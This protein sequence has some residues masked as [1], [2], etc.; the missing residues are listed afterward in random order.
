MSRNST[1]SADEAALTYVSVWKS[2]AS[3]LKL[4]GQLSINPLNSPFARRLSNHYQVE[5]KDL[6][7]LE[8]ISYREESLV[9]GQEILRRG[10][11]LSIQ[12]YRAPVP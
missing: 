11:E 5:E 9:P 4:G 3:H 6:E 2:S 7:Q 8:G 10:Q 12:A 1:H